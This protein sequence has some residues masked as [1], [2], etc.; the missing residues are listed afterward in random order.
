MGKPLNQQ[1]RG[2]GSPTF[3]SPKHR[4]APRSGFGKLFGKGVVID[5]MRDP[6]RS[7]PLAVIKHEDG[8]T[9][10][11]AANGLS[12]GQIIDIG[13][14]AIS[15]KGNILPL[16]NIAEGE[17][18]FCIELRPGD[19]GKLVRG[20]GGSAVIMSRDEN[21][22]RLKLPSGQ[23]KMFLPNC[24]AIVGVAAGGGIR[25][26]PIMKAGKKYHMMAS[27]HT[28]WPRV[29]AV[30]MNAVEHPFG[31]GRKHGHAGKPQTSS[32]HAPPGR[33]VGY[34]AASRTGRKSRAAKKK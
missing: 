4:Y 8:E 29:S 21:G 23:V 14:D 34:I 10:V 25:D 27:K 18:V 11:P 20:A 12:V 28:Y 33:K 16:K 7:A 22:V 9:I 15:T 32:R 31:G 19:G 26:K 30:A 13:D 2:K 5:L 6:Q 1:R 24:R 17:K 3:R